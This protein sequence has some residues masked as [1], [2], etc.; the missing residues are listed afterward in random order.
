M[1]S[2]IDGNSLNLF[3]ADVEKMGA[4]KQPRDFTNRLK[5]TEEGQPCLKCGTPVV[6]RRHRGRWKP[7]PEQPYYFEYWFKCPNRTCKTL[8]MVEAA[9]VWL[10][11]K[12]QPKEHQPTVDQ[13][14]KTRM[15]RED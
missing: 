7:K 10:K 14:Y 3:G 11:D 9:K 15:A 1:G 12:P 13:E 8:W 5:V 4:A 6:E 2:K